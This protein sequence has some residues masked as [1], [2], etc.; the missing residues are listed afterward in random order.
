MADLKLCPFCGSTAKFVFH[1]QVTG[2]VMVECESK[3]ALMGCH[4]STDWGATEGVWARWN[5]R[6]LEDALQRTLKAETDRARLAESKAE[7]F[8]ESIR[9]E[10]NHMGKDAVRVREGGGPENLAASIAVTFA[11]L[12]HYKQILSAPD[13]DPCP[14]KPSPSG[15]CETCKVYKTLENDL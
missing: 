2:L 9:A 10:L 12:R 15:F 7:S 11:K 8:E 13:H 6:P 14:H 4:G 3:N 5:N 1:P